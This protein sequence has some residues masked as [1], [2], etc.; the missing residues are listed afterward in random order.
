MK[1]LLLLLLA[2]TF[3]VFG[4]SFDRYHSQVEIIQYLQGLASAHPKLVKAERIGVSDE[5][6]EI[7]I[8]F[9]AKNADRRLPALYLNGTHHG[10]EKSSTESVLA[11]LDN[12]VTNRELPSVK[13]LL[14]KYAFIL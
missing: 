2:S 8:A 7:W 3:P 6:R 12:L 9:V 11:F 4:I 1:K 10:N 13:A 5:G 14:E